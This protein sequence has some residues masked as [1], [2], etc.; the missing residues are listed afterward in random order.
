MRNLIKKHAFG[1]TISHSNELLASNV[2]FLLKILKVVKSLRT[3]FYM[4][5]SVTF[6]AVLSSETI[7]TEAFKSIICIVCLTSACILARIR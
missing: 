6:L 3:Y 1:L 2:V 4:L 7:L 5:N